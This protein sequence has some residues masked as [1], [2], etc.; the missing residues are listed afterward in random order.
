MKGSKHKLQKFHRQGRLP[1][2]C[3]TRSRAIFGVLLPV[4]LIMIIFPAVAAGSDSCPGCGMVWTDTCV[5]FEN[6]NETAYNEELAAA[7]AP[8][9]ANM[10]PVANFSNESWSD[11]FL[12]LH[13]LIKERYA[14]T[15]WRSVDWDTLYQTYAPAIADAEKKQDKAAYYRT[16]REYLYAVPDGHVVI[17]ATE[18]EFGAKKADIGGGFGLTLVQLDSG[19]V[20]VGYV[21]NGS[22]AD[23]EGIRFGDEVTAWNGLAIHEAINATSPIWAYKKPSTEEGIQIQKTRLLTRAPVGTPA[24]ITVV[25]GTL[26]RTVNLTAYDDGYD[27]VKKGTFFLGKEINDLG[28][29][30]PLTDITPQISNDTVTVRT[31]P[32]GYTSIAVYGESYAVYQPF[33]AAML[34]LIANKTPGVVI[35]LRFN[36]GGDDNLASCMAGWF[37]NKPVF[38]EYATMYDPGSR[39]FPVATEAW[40]QPQPVR[41]TGPVAVLVSPDT[42]S[43]GEGIPKIFAQSGTGAIVSWYG[44][45]GAFGMNNIQAILPLGKYIFFPTGASL[46]QNGTIQVDSSASLAGGIAPTIRVPL[47]ED[48]LKRAMT[49]E[50]VQLTYAMEWLDSQQ[51]Q[52]ASVAASVP[53]TPTQKASLVPALPLVALGILVAIAGR[54]K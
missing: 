19:D 13:T 5:P 18:S 28:A 10:T 2:V 20:V 23:K 31:L 37:V 52:N 46:D 47:N 12:S 45:N 29:G 26:L 48:T 38:Y 54:R 8:I 49:G 36:S 53:A 41:Y 14:F 44:T 3:A 30:N 42:I 21:A 34:S 17:L 51:K 25:R 11:A 9:A 24:M 33:R 22:A 6:N 4:L 43:S 39:K 40:T 15:R 16:L 27:T 32:G 35:D 1:L 7:F 50:D